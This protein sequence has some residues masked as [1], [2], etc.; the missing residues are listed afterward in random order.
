MDIL[1]GVQEVV[2]MNGDQGIFNFKVIPNLSLTEILT[3]IVDCEPDD[4][5]ICFN[6]QWPEFQQIIRNEDIAGIESSLSSRCNPSLYLTHKLRYTNNQKVSF[7]QM[8]DNPDQLIKSI[9]NN[10]NEKRDKFM[11]SLNIQL[12]QQIETDEESPKPQYFV[13]FLIKKQFQDAFIKHYNDQLIYQ[14]KVQHYKNRLQAFQENRHKQY[15]KIVYNLIGAQKALEFLEQKFKQQRKYFLS[16]YS[17]IFYQKNFKLCYEAISH[18]DTGIDQLKINVYQEFVPQV[19][20]YLDEYSKSICQQQ[21]QHIK[22]TVISGENTIK[23]IEEKLSVKQEVFM[24]KK[25]SIT[26]TKAGM[27]VLS[28]WVKSQYY[29]Q[30]QLFINECMMKEPPKQKQKKYKLTIKAI[31]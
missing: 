14:Q 9:E 16:Y 1:L 4:G 21:L 17:I 6:G 28:F 3:C 23:L 8:C 26:T 5:S 10:L 29:E 19:L 31:K 22:T 11:K 15:S 27:E 18:M 12:K 25:P 7:K 24:H 20:N 30:I 2:K 13:Q